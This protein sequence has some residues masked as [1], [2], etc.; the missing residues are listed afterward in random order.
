MGW[1]RRK[2]NSV[3]TPSFAEHFD[4]AI[5]PEGEDDSPEIELHDFDSQTATT[6]LAVAPPSSLATTANP[7]E[8][9]AI[10]THKIE[11]ALGA[12]VALTQQLDN[13]LDHLEARMN[14]LAHNDDLATRDELDRVRHTQQQLAAE[15]SRQSIDLRERLAH[16]ASTRPP[17]PPKDQRTAIVA[18]QILQLSD[19]YNAYDMPGD[20]TDSDPIDLTDA[21]DIA[22]AADI[23]DSPNGVAGGASSPQDASTPATP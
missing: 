16:V 3:S 5:E 2:D 13:R 7:T 20:A 15:I 17:M 6:D 8:L 19:A 10:H 11:K 22:D 4:A 21:S 9:V 12:L 23:A 18:Q 1:F 14:Q